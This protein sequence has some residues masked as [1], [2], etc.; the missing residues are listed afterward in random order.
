MQLNPDLSIEI[1]G[2]VNV[3]YDEI[4]AYP[5]KPGQTPAEYVMARKA[6][7][8]KTLSAKRAELVLNYLLRN[9]ISASRMT[10]KGYNNSKMVCPFISCNSTQQE[11]NRRVEITVTGKTGH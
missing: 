5:L 8:E 1:G 9:G 3:P 2:H 4:N 6:S 10:A 11:M 7:W